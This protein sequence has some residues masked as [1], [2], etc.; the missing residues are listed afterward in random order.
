MW[1]GVSGVGYRNERATYTESTVIDG[2]EESEQRMTE[3]SETIRNLATIG[4]LFS[5]HSNL[6]PRS[7][8][9]SLYMAFFILA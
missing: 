3:P 7:M 6:N 2:L 5:E 1:W 8:S 4:G 9:F